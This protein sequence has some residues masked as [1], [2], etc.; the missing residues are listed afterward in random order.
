MADIKRRHSLHQTR[1]AVEFSEALAK[2]GVDL[3]E[4]LGAYANA[5]NP[6][7]V[8]L[9]GSLA[10]GLANEASDIDL[11]I[12]LDRREDGRDL[13]EGLGLHAGRAVEQLFYRNGLEINVE[14]FVREDVER[15]MTGFVTLAPALY[16]PSKLDR[17]PLLQPYDLRFL[18]R[19]KTGWPLRG[20][21]TVARWRD[22]LLTA[23]LPTYLAL[24]NF[25]QFDEHFEDAM[26]MRADHP[27]ASIF[28]GRI[29]V[30]SALL[31]LLAT[32]GFTNQ[33]R[34]WLVHLCDK[35]RPTAAGALLMEGRALLLES[36]G[37]ADAV[38]FTDRVGA[39]GR[40]LTGHMRSDPEL[41]S[42]I[43]FLREQ[44]SYVPVPPSPVNA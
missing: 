28:I 15:L 5:T 13:S 7:G 12:L 1:T 19:L 37:E 42:A 24:L 29:C 31:A 39:F 34:K 3:D 8:M 14:A 27:A 40:Q 35:A 30:E 17:I 44:I 16:D 10:E 20:Q 38:D 18:H 25:N 9:V 2:E 23:L 22:E 6:P 21:A 26:S 43:D 41:R 36:C 11:L 4:V 32:V 33:N